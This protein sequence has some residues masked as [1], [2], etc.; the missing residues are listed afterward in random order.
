MESNAYA[1]TE[2]NTCDAIDIE[3][4]LLF[5]S[6]NSSNNITETAVSG[7]TKIPI[8][9][10]GFVREVRKSKVAT[11]QEIKLVLVTKPKNMPSPCQ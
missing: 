4:S 11:T 2:R 5:V 7:Y 3:T 9:W 10:T 6:G 8:T 1:P